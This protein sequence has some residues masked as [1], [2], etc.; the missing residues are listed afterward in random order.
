VSRAQRSL[1]GIVMLAL[2]AA[3]ALMGG[4]AAWGQEQPKITLALTVEQAQFM[5]QVLGQ[6]GGCDR[7]SGLATCRAAEELLKVI[8]EQAK[9]QVK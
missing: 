8:L 4:A 6:V 5:T 2:L 7:V 9:Q 1:C 3:G